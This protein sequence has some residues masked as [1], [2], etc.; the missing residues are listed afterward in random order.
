MVTETILVVEDERDI[1][2]LIEYN[3]HEAGYHVL[4]AMNGQEALD[5]ARKQRPDL[6][7]LDLML[8]GLDGKEVCR[9]IKQDESL[10][11]IPV[12]MLTAKAEEVDRIVGLELGADDYMT[13]PFSPR[14]LVLRVKAVL[15]RTL[16][17]PE[18]PAVIRF[19]G[20]VIDSERHRVEVGGE[21]IVLTAT[22]FKLLSHLASRPGRV[23]T[24]EMLLDEVWGYPY[25]GYARTVDTHVRRL[26]KK[27]GP[28][29]D[30]V[31]TIRGVGY[32]FHEDK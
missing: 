28:L 18:L 11:Q 23:Q 13:K 14:E 7:V 8:P 2:D 6:V 29:K 1:L 17:P 12:V 19:P 30:C 20:L 15:R 27:L 32:R 26:R 3:L 21:E 10:R 5:L 9:R 24:R 25:E 16:A 31:E 22:E 4:R